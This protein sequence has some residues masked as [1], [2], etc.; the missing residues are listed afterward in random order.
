MITRYKTAEVA[1]VCDPDGGG[2]RNGWCRWDEVEALLLQRA[3]EI[4]EL[5]AEARDYEEREAAVCPEDVG[6]DEYIRVLTKQLTA[7]AQEIEQVKAER[8]AFRELSK[9]ASEIMTITYAGN[10]P[11]GIEGFLI[12]AHRAEAALKEQE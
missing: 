9:E 1:R 2:V 5:K 7:R 10:F 6:F 4:A 8:D 3:Q 11:A 12:R